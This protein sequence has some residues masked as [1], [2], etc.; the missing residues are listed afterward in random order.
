MKNYHSPDEFTGKIIDQLNHDA[1]DIRPDIA[2]RL[3]ENRRRSL[4]ILDRP[5]VH[6]IPRWLTLSGFATMAMLVIA[7]SLW[8]RTPKPSDLDLHPEDME[9]I[10]SQEQI[11]FY[12]D[13]DFYRWLEGRGDD[14]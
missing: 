3:G 13:L 9:V 1:A 6:S 8:I 10:N 4:E 11:E 5:F 7:V 2:S 12:R 14:R